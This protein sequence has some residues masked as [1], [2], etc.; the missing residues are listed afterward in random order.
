MGTIHYNLIEFVLVEYVDDGE[1]ANELRILRSRT[2]KT[3]GER[4]DSVSVKDWIHENE[5]LATRVV[6]Q[7][8]IWNVLAWESSLYIS[9]ITEYGISMSNVVKIMRIASYELT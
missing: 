6:F 9:E 8:G 4:H 1:S 5:E 7:D 2:P 3:I